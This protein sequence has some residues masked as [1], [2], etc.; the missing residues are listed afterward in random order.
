MHNAPNTP[1]E[2]IEEDA[3]EQANC[4]LCKSL[5]R[6]FNHIIQNQD[7]SRQDI[8]EQLEKYD[9]SKSK[10]KR[11]LA[12]AAEK[13]EVTVDDLAKLALIFNMRVSIQFK[14]ADTICLN[15]DLPNIK[16]KPFDR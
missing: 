4:A 5:Q 13:G 8:T 11:W 15:W 3:H 2:H 6:V 10:I 7:R 12:G 1:R 14:Q 16:P 9:I